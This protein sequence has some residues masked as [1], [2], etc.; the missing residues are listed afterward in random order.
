MGKYCRHC[1]KTS[2]VEGYTKFC[3]YCGT[4]YED[5]E[6]SQR[7]PEETSP[8]TASTQSQSSGADHGKYVP[9]EDREKHGFIGALYETWRE[10]IFSPTNFFRRMPVK[11]G[12]GNPLIYGLLLGF[13]GL[14]FELVYNQ[15]FS[16]MFDPSSWY[17]FIGEE[18][19]Y[20][21]N[22]F[23]RQFESISTLVMI[24]V[25]PFLLTAIL[26]IW[27]GII[28]LIMVIFGWRKEDYEATFRLVCYSESTSFFQII[29][30]IGSLVGGIWGIVLVI[31]GL[32][33]VHRLTIGQAIIVA[34]LPFILCCVCCCGFISLFA[35]MAGLTN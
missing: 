20:E 23:M 28:H 35:G 6:Q 33:E 16:Q 18:F 8:I 2:S 12:L 10:S 15:L 11:G 7:R 24:I 4:A 22:E 5:A 27:S 17:P 31:I 29:P 1:S 14:I 34:L 19:D 30:F 21:L 25:F 26:F 13:V 3:P 32:K 9:W